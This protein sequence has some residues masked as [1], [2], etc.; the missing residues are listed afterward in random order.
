MT[1]S[2]AKTSDA[3]LRRFILTT[4]MRSCSEREFAPSFRDDPKDQVRNDGI[5]SALDFGLVDFGTGFIDHDNAPALTVVIKVD[6]DLMGNQIGG[7]LRV[8]LVFAIQPD[9]IFE[10]NAVGNIKMKNGHRDSSSGI[11]AP[12]RN[13]FRNSEKEADLKSSIARKF[14][15]VSGVAAPSSS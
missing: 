4:M 10:T 7:F 15:A 13:L 3:R 14:P 12:T 1:A 5:L 9:W 8:I 11:N 6:G 2:A